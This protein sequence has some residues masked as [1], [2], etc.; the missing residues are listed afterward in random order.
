MVNNTDN[1]CAK[2]GNMGLKS[3]VYNQERVIMARERYMYNTMI[4]FLRLSFGKYV[5]S[6][7]RKTLG[8]I[9]ENRLLKKLQI[10]RNAYFLYKKKTKH[11]NFPNFNILTF[12]F[13]MT[14]YFHTISDWNYLFQF[15]LRTLF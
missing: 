8:T 10:R 13:E 15:T 6:F 2:Q 12:P 14:C 7:I 1:L 5:A 9:L 3:A 4:Y 11:N